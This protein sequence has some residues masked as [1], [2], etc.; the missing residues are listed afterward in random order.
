MILSF[1]LI[2][3]GFGQT[4]WYEVQTGFDN[5]LNCIEFPSENVGYIGGNDTLLLKSV[6][7]GMTWAQLQPIG[8]N[9]FPGGEHVL[10]LKFIT[11]TTGYMI[12]GPYGNVYK[13]IDGGINW[14]SITVSGN[15]C[16]QD[17][18]YFFSENDG[19]IGG[20]GCFEGE[21]IDLYDGSTINQ[22]TMND[23][24]LGGG[25]SESIVDFDFYSANFGLAAS[26]AGRIF[27]TID[28]GQ[29]WDSIAINVGQNATL[30]SIEI[31][32]DTVAYAGLSY[33]GG[34]N[35]VLKTI[36]SGLTWFVD[37]YTPFPV[38]TMNF[39]DTHLAPN[40]RLFAPCTMV[41][42]T[43]FRIFENPSVGAGS[44]SAI[45]EQSSVNQ[46]IYNMTSYS[47]SIVWGVGDSGYVIV[48]V[49]PATLSFGESIIKAND[50]EL[51]PNP[52]SGHVMLQSNDKIV[53]GCIYNL[54][55]K[56]VQVLSSI[57]NQIDVNDLDNGVYLLQ[58][59]FNDRV[60]SVRFVKE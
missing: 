19:F 39:H 46:P 45:W 37:T 3:I 23:N 54:S 40:G 43:G 5:Q 38:L 58:V 17:A 15:L 25:P 60:E 8:L 4:T 21:L 30:S 7:G 35:G 26:A 14:A 53:S 27:R 6:D 44:P 41:S 34:S 59:Q 22:A 24:G 31:T 29:N 42:T 11:E 2:Q 56:K 20:S 12:V 57:S 9:V 28:G 18:L 1:L 51:Y 48:N 33:P 32:N 47:D 49:P 52:T 50:L 10:D 55:G 13:T 36:D 16:Y